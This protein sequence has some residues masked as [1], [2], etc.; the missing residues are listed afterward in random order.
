MIIGNRTPNEIF[1][2]RKNKSPK[3]I[4][5][6]SEFKGMIYLTRFANDIALPVP[7]TEKSY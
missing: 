2:G 4:S 1:T 7:E 5:I 6:G 3:K